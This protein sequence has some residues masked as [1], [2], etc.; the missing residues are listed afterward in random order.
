MSFLA[1]PECTVKIAEP[2]G[3]WTVW[4]DEEAAPLHKVQ[5]RGD[6]ERTL[7]AYTDHD[8]MYIES[9]TS[10]QYTWNHVRRC[11]ERI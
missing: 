4:I 6:A 7:L 9:P 10:E 8:Y 11:W 1:S 5:H 2:A 3:P